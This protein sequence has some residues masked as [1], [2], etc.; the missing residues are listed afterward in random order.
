MC[1]SRNLLNFL[2]IF[3]KIKE[4]GT[5]PNYEFTIILITKPDKDTSKKERKRKLQ[6]NIFDAA[7][8]ILYLPILVIMCLD[9]VLFGFIF[10]RTLCF[11]Y[12]DN[13]LLLQFWGIFSQNFIKYIFNP[14]LS[15]S[16]EKDCLLSLFLSTLFFLIYLKCDCIH[17]FLFWLLIVSISVYTIVVT[18]SFIVSVS[19]FTG[20]N[21]TEFIF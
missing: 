3:Y 4:E 9:V 15:S 19:N 21:L 17:N 18:V 16:Y 2:K 5:L 7:T 1:I 6:V 14:L 13:Y 10:F 12:L 11:F 8:K 20:W